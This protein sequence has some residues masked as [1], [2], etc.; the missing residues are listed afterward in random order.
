MATRSFFKFVLQV[1]VKKK[2][3][4]FTPA[5]QGQGKAIRQSQLG[6]FSSRSKG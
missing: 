6:I 5:S 4:S 3:N 2:G 1:Q